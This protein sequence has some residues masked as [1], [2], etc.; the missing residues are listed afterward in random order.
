MHHR[1]SWV[2]PRWC[3]V[4]AL[5]VIGAITACSDSTTGTRTQPL[6]DDRLVAFVSDSGNLDF[7][8]SSIF[9]MHADGSHTTR[10]TSSGYNDETPAWSPDGSTIAFYSDRPPVGIWA[11]NADGSNLRSLVSA[12]FNFPG[13]PAWSPNGRS[14]AFST[15]VT[16]SLDNFV[17]IIEIADAD[18]SNAHRL[19]TV[20]ADV[21]SPSWSPDG[22]RILF[23]AGASSNSHI[24]VVRTDGTAEQQITTGID[25]Q[26]QWSPDG[27]QIAFTTLDANNYNPLAKITVTMADGS[28]RRTLTTG[29]TKRKPSWSPDGRQ[30]AY[31]GFERDSTAGSSLTPLRVYRMNA[32]GSDKRLMSSD[33]AP[34][35]P[36][37]RSWSPVWKPTP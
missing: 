1:P 24:S 4:F 20:A 37:F 16:D 15:Y 33:S 12:P 21:A 19:T 5:A 31:E 3:A 7:G 36:N 35:L 18:G 6:V 11:V 13:E 29:G 27:R 9:V 23:V 2:V 32:D 34:S 26:P 17:D 10:V 14:L 8:G 28:N 30:I 22:T 25:W